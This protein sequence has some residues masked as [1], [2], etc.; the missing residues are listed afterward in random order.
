M[1]MSSPFEQPYMIHG[2]GDFIPCIVGLDVYIAQY[3]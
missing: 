3:F 2:I 1:G